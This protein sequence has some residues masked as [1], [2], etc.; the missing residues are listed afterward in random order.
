[1]TERAFFPPRDRS[2]GVSYKLAVSI[3]RFKRSH[4][5]GRASIT[6]EQKE[7]LLFLAADG[8]AEVERH[9]RRML[10]LDLG[11][12][13]NPICNGPRPEEQEGSRARRCQ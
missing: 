11:L 2:G 12:F 4:L 1:M 7:R 8:E 9:S 5:K 13:P 6:G 3:K 10:G